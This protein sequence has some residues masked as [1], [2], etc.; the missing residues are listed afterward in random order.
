LAGAYYQQCSGCHGESGSGVGKFPSR[1]NAENGK[2]FDEFVKVVRDGK[3]GQAGVMPAFKESHLSESELLQVYAAL[4]GTSVKATKTLGC[5]NAAQ[6]NDTE[7]EA[8]FERGLASWRAPDFEDAACASCHGPMPIDIAYIGYDDATIFRRALKHITEEQTR[9]VIDFV[10]AIR[11]KYDIDGPK[12]FLDF[13]PFQPGGRVIEGETV[14]ERDHNFGLNVRQVAPS[15][16]DGVLDTTEEA[17]AARDEMLALNPR[18][19]PIGVALN[20]WTEDM[21]HGKEHATLNE[22][23][24]DRPHIPVDAESQKALYALHDKYIENPSWENLFAIQDANKKLTRLTGVEPNRGP[25]NNKHDA[26]A[27]DSYR[28]KYESVLFAQHHFLEELRG[29]PTLASMS[30]APFPERNSVW[31]LGDLARVMDSVHFTNDCKNTWNGCLGLPPDAVEKI[32]PSFDP[33]QMLTDL[34]LSWFWAGWFV[35]T[36]LYRT[37]ATNSTRVSEYFTGEI[38]NRGYYNHTVYHRFRKNLATAYEHKG[39]PDDS[40]TRLG[41][42]HP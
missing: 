23:I 18:T 10:H 3:K 27:Y 13:R 7:I 30:A 39:S 31:E 15:L 2:G 16:F 20:R 21:H 12:A 24:P 29:K 41:V 36:T 9:D 34:K 42:D 4:K 33:R 22:W 37:S 32:D 6:L 26:R 17:L 11:A 1:T 19:F 38:Y 40:N 14:A 5:S 25:S 28:L 8:A 35:D